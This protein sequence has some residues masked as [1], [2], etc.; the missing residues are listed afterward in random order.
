MYSAPVRVWILGSG[1]SGNATIVEAG[2]ARVLID[3]GMGPRALANRMAAHGA[4][5]LYAG[6]LDAIVVTHE[7]QDHVAHLEAHAR[8]FDAPVY[9]H[10]G[11]AAREV[12]DRYEV[13]P[14]EARAPFRVGPFSIE[15]LSV[16][17]DAPQ[18]AL[19]IA[20]EQHAFGL[21]TDVGHV[22]PDLAPFLGTCDAALV[23]ANYCPEL[24]WIGPYPTFLKRRVSGGLGHLAN[25]EAAELA[26]RLVG[27]RLA[28]LVLGH[29]SRTNNEPERA[30]AA[31]RQR[32]GPLDVRMVRPGAVSVLDMASLEAAAS[33]GARGSVTKAGKN[34]RRSAAAQLT[35]GF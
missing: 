28:R 23:E 17:H 4:G 5:K 33:S 34:A 11:I 29:V 6:D 9:L 26:S 16:P 1:S 18:V 24:L 12:R 31:V 8:T 20:T 14:Y 13:R 19:R 10:H 22:P 27:T 32:S 3:C 30:L 2:G 25:H 35:F 21:V 7:H 15:A